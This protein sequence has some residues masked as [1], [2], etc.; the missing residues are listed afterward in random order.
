MLENNELD[1][2]SIRLIQGSNPAWYDL[3][4]DCVAFANAYG[5]KI[6]IGHEIPLR[7]IRLQ[8]DNLVNAEIVQKKG[9]KK[10]TKYFLKE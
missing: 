3:A 7:S 2:K 8:L 4:K 6:L 10:S 5:G 9:L 1:K